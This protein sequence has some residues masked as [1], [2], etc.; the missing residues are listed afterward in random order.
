MLKTLVNKPAYR[1]ED[2]GAGLPMEGCVGLCNGAYGWLPLG[3]P[4]GV[5]ALDAVGL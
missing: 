3:A 4:V 5:E 2:E 1:D